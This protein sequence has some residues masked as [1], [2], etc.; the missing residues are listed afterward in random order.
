MCIA[1]AARAALVRWA[2]SPTLD[3]YPDPHVTA[4]RTALAARHQLPAAS[5]TFGPGSMEIIDRALGVYGGPVVVAGPAWDGLL[6]LAARRGVE[7][8]VADYDVDAIAT[9]CDASTR[10]VYVSSPSYPLG[11][12]LGDPAALLAR[13]PATLLWDE[14]FVEYGRQPSALGLL[15]HDRLIVVRTF[16]KIFGLAGL[17]V[18]WAAGATE[19]LRAAE[20]LYPISGPAQIAA[21]AALG[22]DAFVEAARALNAS[23]RD[24]IEAALGARK[25]PYI[26]SEAS[27]IWAGRV[28]DIGRPEQNDKLISSL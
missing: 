3:A 25:L 23:E 12:A 11:R 26:P 8:R 19:R 14:A 7:I 10:L 22:D 17:R 18:G 13:I 5:L 1:P 6:E 20:P 27:F 15:P 4:L 28:L 24:R 16:S 9:A 2:E 21:V